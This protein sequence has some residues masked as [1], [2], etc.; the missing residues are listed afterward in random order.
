MS[1]RASR[2][3]APIRTE[4]R[5]PDI[6]R[7]ALEVENAERGTELPVRLRVKSNVRGSPWRRTSTL[8]SEPTPI[9][10]VEWGR[11]GRAIRRFVR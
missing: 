2:A 7:G 9:G 11:F 6:L 3:P 10:T 4:N 5:A 8:P 1:A